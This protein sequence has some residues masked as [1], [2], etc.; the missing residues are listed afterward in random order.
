MLKNVLQEEVHK[1]FLLEYQF[2]MCV[3][4]GW[5]KFFWELFAVFIFLTFSLTASVA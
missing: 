3:F 2:I 1:L 4:D 5:I